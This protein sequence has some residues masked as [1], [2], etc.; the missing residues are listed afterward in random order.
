MN[1]HIEV[2]K[3]W[4]ADNDSVTLEELRDNRDSAYAAADAAYAADDADAAEA[5]YWVERYERL[6]K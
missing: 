6:T 3:K 2:V 1:P 4:M 5:A